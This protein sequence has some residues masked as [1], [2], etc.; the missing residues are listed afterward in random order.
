MVTGNPH[1]RFW[2]WK[3]LAQ[4]RALVLLRDS[5]VRTLVGVQKYSGK[6]KVFANTHETVHAG[7]IIGVSTTDGWVR[8]PVWAEAVPITTSLR[9]H[10]S[11]ELAS[12]LPLGPPRVTAEMLTHHPSQTQKKHPAAPE[13]LRAW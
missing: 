8:W 5:S 10:A 4:H 1:T 13:M 2:F 9:L 11:L 6:C 7:D 12:P 3:A